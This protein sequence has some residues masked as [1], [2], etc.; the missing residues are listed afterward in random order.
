MA[1]LA[2]TY[3]GLPLRNPL[4][5]AASSVTARIE[6]LELCDRFG[7]GAVVLRSLFEEQILADRSQLEEVLDTASGSHAEAQDYFPPVSHA[8]ATDYLRRIEESKKAVSIPIIASLNAVNNGSWTR[9]ARQMVEAGA[10]AIELNV[11]SVATDLNVSS[12]QIEEQLL[13]LVEGVLS[14]ASVPVSVKLSPYYTSLVNVV[15]QLDQRKVG[16]VVLFNRFLQPD[17]D[18]QSETLTNAMPLSSPNELRLPLRYVALLAGR[19]KCDLAIST[20]VHRGEDMV[21]AILAGA[22]VTQIAASVIKNG[23]HH[24]ATMLRDLEAWMDERGHHSVDDL[25]GRLSQQAVNDPFAFERAQ[26]VNLLLSGGALSG[27]LNAR[28]N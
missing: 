2:T 24:I 13:E 6:N 16:G 9:Y 15:G 19:V 18:P 4:V 28:V 27:P 11:Y 25:R 17:I 14:V 20:G 23:I 7:A 3:L 8:D 5:I 1:D 12:Q 21:R 10:D 26:Y 22:T